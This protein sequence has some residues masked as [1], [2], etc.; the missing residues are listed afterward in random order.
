MVV[1]WPA[2]PSAVAAT[3][4]SG[5]PRVGFLGQARSEKG[6]YLLAEALELLK[7]PH[8]I[9]LHA[10]PAPGEPVVDL[11]D[12]IVL[13]GLINAHCHLD[14]SMMRGAISPPKSFTAWVQR[15]NALKRSLDADDYLA[16]IQRGIAELRRWGTTS[17]ANIEA[18]P[19][20]MP[21]IPP[22]PLRIWWFYEMIDVRHRITTEDV[23]AGA[24]SFFN[25]QAPGGETGGGGRR[26]GRKGPSA[27]RG[28]TARRV[29]VATS[30]M[31]HRPPTILQRHVR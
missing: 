7:E 13:P 9:E 20:L 10:S 24:L 4:R 17:V 27:R 8:Q 25:Q 12:H 22:A 21:R 5:P 29:P 6:F 23:V 2:S 11:R 3:E 30:A 26:R 18:F 28:V 14:Y 15:I 31:V 1:S 16:A 19:E